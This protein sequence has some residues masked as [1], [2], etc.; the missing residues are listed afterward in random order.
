MDQAH[1]LA[2]T[3]VH[4]RP[5]HARRAETKPQVQ[6]N[7][8]S[9]QRDSEPEE[10]SDDDDDVDVDDMEE[11]EDTLPDADDATDADGMEAEPTGPQF[12]PIA[13]RLSL[14]AKGGPSA[15][16]LMRQAQAR[17][18]PRVLKANAVKVRGLG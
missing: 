7:V 4:S 10:T 12:D 6:L 2:N 5:K 11:V 14:K 1:T 8:A 15:A 18:H 3:D 13:Y 16:E 9:T 17:N